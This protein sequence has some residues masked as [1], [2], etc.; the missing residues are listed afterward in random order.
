MNENRVRVHVSVV[1]VVVVEVEVWAA[2]WLGT[3]GLVG[4][5]VGQ[6]AEPTR[7]AL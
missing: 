3:L 7:G 4:R 2:C 1:V 5:T 6:D